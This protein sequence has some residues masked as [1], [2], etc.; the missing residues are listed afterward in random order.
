[1][2]WIEIIIEISSKY[3]DTVSELAQLVNPD[4]IYI[5]DYSH[6]EKDIMEI[7]HTDLID[8]QL[9][10]KARNIAK[11]HIY[12][13]NSNNIDSSI[14]FLNKKLNENHIS[15]TITKKS[16]S[17]TNEWETKWQE[18][19]HPLKIGKN[20]I[21]C[22]KWEKIDTN[23]DEI[24]VILNPGISF[25]TGKHET[26]QMCI[27][28]LETLITPNCTVLDIG[29]GSGILSITSILLGA[30]S[31]LGV[32][33]D[34]LAVKIAKENAQLNNIDEGSFKFLCGNLTEKIHGKFDV[35]CANI[36]SDIIIELSA[37]ITKFMHSETKFICSGIIAE[38]E[39]E[40]INK[41]N[42]NNLIP[43][44]IKR[45]KDW[46]SICFKLKK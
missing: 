44:K 25:G 8:S 26:T 43:Q 40:V 31:S 33:I 21:I 4:S 19:Y 34:P 1:M 30:K 22:P 9:K 11:V 13:Q 23:S 20:V 45:N 2:N 41:L 28:F 46:V 39:I 16:I 15:S 7:A 42:Q 32:D 3:T 18:F 29:C 10:N 12:L 17:N 5:E 14:D 35:I 6:L 36:V 38:R 24:K 37:N 27:E